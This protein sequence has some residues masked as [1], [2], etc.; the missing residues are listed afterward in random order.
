VRW[1]AFD[2]K[3][4]DDVDHEDLERLI[5]D[6][7]EEGLFLE[8]KSGWESRKVARAVASF[9]NTWGGTVVVGMEA[10]G[11]KPTNLVGLDYDE[12]LE[13][14][15]V[16]TIRAS[17]A[18]I[19]AFWPRA[20]DVGNG[21]AAV[22]VEVPSGTQTPY[23]LI[24][25]GQILVRT[26]TS[27][28]PVGINDRDALDRLFARGDRG[29]RWASVN[30]HAIVGQAF[31]SSTDY[32]HLWTIPAVHEGLAVQPI[33]HRQTFFS[34]I[35]ALTRSFGF[36]SGIRTAEPAMGA[37]FMQAKCGTVFEDGWFLTR[38]YV[39][40]I[41]EQRWQVE[42]VG[43]G[44]ESIQ[45]LLREGLPMHRTILE[46]HLGHRGDVAVALFNRWRGPNDGSV[47][48]VKLVRERVPAWDLGNTELVDAISR[49]MQRERGGLAFEPEP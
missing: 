20:V 15:V 18:P 16:N 31:E 46:E 1:R 40:G 41:I 14:R 10:R 27:S 2:P 36:V 28:E 22:V 37:D 34:T 4:L 8:Y 3:P 42:Q 47:H 32:P 21:R 29:Y 30:A 49:Q 35:E 45:T 43:S 5:A 44:D 13:E 23:I 17:V 19:P 26:P 24:Q 12:H 48:S 25:T 33:I 39:S 6:E 38:V 9:A 11:L 7:I